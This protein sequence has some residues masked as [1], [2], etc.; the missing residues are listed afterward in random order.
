MEKHITLVG[1]LNIAYRSLMLLG[2]FFLFF[3][4]AFFGD[5]ISML[6]D[7]DVIRPHEIPMPLL[8]LVPLVLVAIAGA[9]TIVSIAGI[10]GGVGVLKRKEWGRIVTLVV[11]FINLLRVPFGT[12]LGIYSIYIL[13]HGD[14]VKVFSAGTPA[15]TAGT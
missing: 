12:A 2:A 14:V 7:M 4:A 3:L 5:L 10:I 1:I 9:M 8:N 15:A 11:S 13:L 6:I